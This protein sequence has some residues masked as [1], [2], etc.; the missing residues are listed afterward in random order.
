MII[1]PPQT[2]DFD[3]VVAL[4]KQAREAGR[5][6]VLTNGVFDLLHL[7]HVEYLHRSA[8]LGDLLLVAVNSD[9]S[10]R[11]LKGPAR[12][13]NCEMD[14][15]YVLAGLRCV[16][17]TFIFPGPRLAQE[18]LALQPDIYTKAGDYTL[19]TL[20]PDERAALDAVGAEIRLMPFVAGHS[21][22]ALIARGANANG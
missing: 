1:P 3:D 10:V 2:L 20:D 11:A 7:G 16:T 18:I 15:A 22:T 5:R 13:L 14:R 8:E 9:A 19:E 17:A 6:V 4:R 21:T 12:P